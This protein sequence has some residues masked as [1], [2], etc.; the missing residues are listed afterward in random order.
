MRILLDTNILLSLQLVEAGAVESTTEPA[1]RLLGQ[2]RKRRLEVFFHPA[3]EKDIARDP[4]PHRRRA[5]SLLLAGHRRLE[6]PPGIPDDWRS[7]WPGVEMGSNDGVDLSHLAALHYQAVDL[8]I[9]EDAGLRRRARRVALGERTLTTAEALLLFRDLFPEAPAPPPAVE[10]CRAYSLDPKDP[11][12]NSFRDDYADFDTWFDRCRRDHRPAWAVRAP[13][14]NLA[15]FV[16][17]KDSE[18]E[19]PV[20]LSGR[21][22]KICSLKVAEESLGL[23]LG[24]LLLKAVFDHARSLKADWL[25]LSV[26][27]HHE[28]LIE[29][30]EDFGFRRH[31]IPTR[32]AAFA[33]GVVE[34]TFRSSAPEEI[35]R[36]VARRTVYSFD[37]ITQLC[38]KRAVLSI[39]F[40]YAERLVRTITYEE[41]L[42]GGVLQGP[43]QS[44]QSVPSEGI[45]WLL[46][47]RG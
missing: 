8:L 18:S 6:A 12:F 25:F 15:A 26:F 41:L 28:Q 37:E 44:I 43:P 45:E 31:E 40:R 33:L 19:P 22:L 16:I 38:S 21:V 42:R 24:E 27:R 32:R 1:S 13:T 20:P 46:Q 7:I 11:I 3:A 35:A 30:L 10:F 4:N 14:G 29:L 2:L 17:V 9:T 23:R 39:L 5:R 36:R 47:H 34:A